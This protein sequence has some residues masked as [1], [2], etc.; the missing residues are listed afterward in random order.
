MKTNIYFKSQQLSQFFYSPEAD[1]ILVCLQET[2]VDEEC[3][4][5]NA[6]LFAATA[7]SRDITR[8]C[9]GAAVA[10]ALQIR[11]TNRHVR[12]Q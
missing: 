11:Y 3:C 9:L 8:Y 4:R 10:R 1:A 5:R 2:N 12:L 7:K 6:L